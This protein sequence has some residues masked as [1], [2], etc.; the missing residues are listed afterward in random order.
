MTSLGQKQPPCRFRDEALTEV[1]AWNSGRVF[2]AC[3]VNLLFSSI[4]IYHSF[5]RIILK[6]RS[7][8]MDSSES[9]IGP[10]TFT[11]GILAHE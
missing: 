11:V 3:P 4:S 8:T 1:D 6:R 5:R 2:R 9:T 7:K 10:S